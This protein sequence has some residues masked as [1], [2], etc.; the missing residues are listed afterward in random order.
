MP[1]PK[2]NKLAIIF[3]TIV[4]EFA[5][6][7]D[8]TAQRKITASFVAPNL[9]QTIRGSPRSRHL[10]QARHRRRC[11][12]LDRQSAGGSNPARWRYRIYDRRR[13]VGDSRAHA[14]RRS[15]DASD[16]GQFSSQRVLLRPE[17]TLQRL[18]DLKGKTVGV[19][20]YGYFFAS[21]AAQYRPA[22]RR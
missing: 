17:S 12:P 16:D 11:Y 8:A 2:P 3:A 10:R 4:A 9:S 18:H 14:W 19:T 21:R 13:T 5:I 15:R 6:S 20:Q 1:V 7:S 22:A